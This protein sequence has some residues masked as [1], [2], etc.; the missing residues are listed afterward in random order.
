M[1]MPMLGAL[2]RIYSCNKYSNLIGQLEI[3]YRLPERSYKIG[4]LRAKKDA[5]CNSS[6]V[7]RPN[8]MVAV[9]I[10]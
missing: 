9:T 6:L 4:L 10:F 3:H 5:Q 7:P 8:V 1:C 2:I